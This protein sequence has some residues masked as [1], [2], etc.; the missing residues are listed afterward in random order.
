[1]KILI[2][3]IFLLIL[4]SVSA[5]GSADLIVEDL[6]LKT[7]VI[8]PK[9]SYH[10]ML[11]LKNIG[12][13]PAITRLPVN[14]WF[15]D[16][17]EEPLF[18][19]SLTQVLTGREITSNLP[20]LNIIKVDGTE[21]MVSAVYEENHIYLAPAESFEEIK[22]RKDSYM[23][24]AES[25]S[26]TPE[27]IKN[28]LKEI[29]TIYSQ[30]HEQTMEGYYLQLNP[31]E[32]VIF[33]SENSY[34][35]F[36]ALNFPVGELSINQLE[37]KIAVRVDPLGEADIVKENNYFSKTILMQPN[38]IQ[39]PKEET[40]KNRE[41]ND[42][43]EYF[44]FAMGCTNIQSREICVYGDDPNIPDEEESLIISVD[45]VEESYSWYG[46]FMAWMYKTFGDGKLAPTKTVNGVDVSIY[47][48]GFKL[49]F[50]D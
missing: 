27:Q 50:E 20:P 24:R 5:L 29:E 37:V 28:D 17:H 14:I 42:A 33:D 21:Q 30:K 32:T 11:Y 47:D 3:S 41:L 19:S 8:E 13:E 46:L 18:P 6:R 49:R 34:K 40:T 10:Y 36:A 15:L 26:Y 23:I 25:L 7:D 1:M 2:A 4:I 45:G 44:A 48:N 9:E 22:K 12:D 35:E 16:I 43:N 39:G 31:G 38:V